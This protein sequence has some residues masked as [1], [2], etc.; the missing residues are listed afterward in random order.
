MGDMW[1]SCEVPRGRYCLGDSLFLYREGEPVSSLRRVRDLFLE[2]DFL[3]RRDEHTTQ[4]ASSRERNTARQR[5]TSSQGRG[6]LGGEGIRGP[7]GRT[8]RSTGADRKFEVLVG[9]VAT[10]R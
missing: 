2:K 1:E 8:V 6:G 3:S 9:S 4:Q 5:G 10:H 7:E